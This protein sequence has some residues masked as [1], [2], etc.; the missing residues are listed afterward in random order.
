M[1]PTWL[2]SFSSRFSIQNLIEST[3]QKLIILLYHG[4]NTGAKIPFID[5]LYP[6]R[7]AEV[8]EQDILFFT[9]H[10]ES[11]SLSQIYA[12]E[13]QFAKPSFHISFDDGLRSVYDAAMPIMKKHKVHGSVFLN[14]NF[15][16]NK[17]LFYRYKVALIIDALQASPSLQNKL[18]KF[19]PPND[20]YTWLLDMKYADARLIDE[21]A[22]EL[23]L[24]FDDFLALEK[25]YLS[26]EQIKEMQAE[27]M[28]LGAHSFDHPLVQNSPTGLSQ[29]ILQ[30]VE[31]I[32]TRFS[33]ALDA[34]AFPFT[35][36]GMSAADFSVVRKV[37][38]MSFGTAG[39][40]SDPMV[41]HYQRIPMERNTR[42]AADIIKDAYLYYR[43]CSWIGKHKIDRA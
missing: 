41:Q 38:K 13:G 35:D 28:E 4:I 11:V 15:I 19:D 12:Q 40:K 21:M 3:G 33:P 22:L 39:L 1:V 43:L 25:P 5:P 7:S 8:F 30:S 2:T 17:G 20:L 31:D 6:S 26:T 14:N 23:G 18:A 29:E 10:F 27:G 42:P 34:F 16:D 24:R 36:A 9:K 32:Q 37:C